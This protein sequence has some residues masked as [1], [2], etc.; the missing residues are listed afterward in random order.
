MT[1]FVG[2]LSGFVPDEEIE[3]AVD[4][5]QG[6]AELVRDG[7]DELIL[8]SIEVEQPVGRLAQ[9]LLASSC[10]LLSLGRARPFEGGRG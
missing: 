1:L 3:V 10:R 2:E 6:S 7:G 4:R 8:Q 9:R 5:C